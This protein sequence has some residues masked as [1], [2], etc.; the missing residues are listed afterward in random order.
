MQL[1]LIKCGIYYIIFLRQRRNSSQ[2]E[3]S[4]QICNIIIIN[5]NVGNQEM[6]C[7]RDNITV[8]LH[9]K[10]QVTKF[11]LWP[12]TK[13]FC[14]EQYLWPHT[15]VHLSNIQSQIMYKAAFPQIIGLSRLLLD[16]NSNLK[17]YHQNEPKK[18]R[19]KQNQRLSKTEYVYHNS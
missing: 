6:E 8:G 17:T 9:Q 3:E 14:F 1:R 13:K 16:P 11:L 19:K 15:Q 4:Q 10:L 18:E 7:L 2:M 12:R 5:L